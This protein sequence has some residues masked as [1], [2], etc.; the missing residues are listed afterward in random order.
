MPLSRRVRLLC[1]MVV[2]GLCFSR[3]LAGL[4]PL[5]VRVQIDAEERV[6]AGLHLK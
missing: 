4:I 5:A 1:L 3:L 2:M 6:D